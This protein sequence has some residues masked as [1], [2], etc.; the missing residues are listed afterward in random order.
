MRHWAFLEALL[1]EM[2]TVV[3]QHLWKSDHINA[4]YKNT[5]VMQNSNSL[6]FILAVQI[7]AWEYTHIETLGKQPGI[8]LIF[9]RNQLWLFQDFRKYTSVHMIYPMPNTANCQSM[10][11]KSFGAESS[12]REKLEACQ[13]KHSQHQSNFKKV[14]KFIWWNNDPTHK[15]SHFPT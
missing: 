2:R 7:T 14:F 5:R 4:Y 13:V 12:C 8:W 10:H 1:E 11:F 3:A 15:F 6:Y 9:L